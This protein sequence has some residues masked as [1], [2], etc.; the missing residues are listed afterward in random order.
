MNLND[1]QTLIESSR[2]GDKLAFTK[3]YESIYK[4]IKAALVLKMKSPQQVEEIFADAM[5]RFWEKFI[6]Y[7]QPLPGNNPEGY[8]YRMCL[9]AWLDL[10]RKKSVEKLYP[11]DAMTD[12][13][14]GKNASGEGE[15]PPESNLKMAVQLEE[16][17]HRALSETIKKLCDKC[18]A[19]YDEHIVGA[20]KIVDL[21]KALGYKNYQA[22][23]MAKYNCRKKIA[24]I[25]YGE[26]ERQS[27]YK[28]PQ[29][30]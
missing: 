18:R 26:L 29:S 27:G 19:L 25:F 11:A 20:K 16:L 3:F 21:W 8:V 9:N 4:N 14:L 6:H 12:E 24:R 23:V 15:L 28:L 10:K 1:Y 17:H 7:G 5:V 22:M 13:L 30:R 2:Q